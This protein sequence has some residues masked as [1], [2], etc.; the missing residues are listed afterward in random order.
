M[1]KKISLI[2][3]SIICFFLESFSQVN[4]DYINSTILEKNTKYIFEFR[5]GTIS[6]G[7]FQ[8][9]ESGNVYII[10]GLELVGNLNF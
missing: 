7:T 6:V 8:K 9:E 5:D 3:F 1:L 2:L 4:S 10:V